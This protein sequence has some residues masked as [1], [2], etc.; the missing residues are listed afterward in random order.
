MSAVRPCRRRCGRDRHDP[1]RTPFPRQG[2]RVPCA[3]PRL[4][5]SSHAPCPLA[6]SERLGTHAERRR[7]QDP[8][9]AWQRLQTTVTAVLQSTVLEAELVALGIGKHHPS[10]GLELAPIVNDGRAEGAESFDLVGL[11]SLS[12]QQVEMHTILHGLPLR[13]RDEDEP[14]KLTVRRGDKPELVARHVDSLD[15]VARDG[16]PEGGDTPR[17]R[18]VECDVEDSSSHR[19]VLQHTAALRS[20]AAFL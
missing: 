12:R 17:I 3:L 6:L 19:V 20:R 8:C 18:A 13:N 15:L 14:G 10:T 4:W 5:L 7:L 1:S 11:L 16:A 9:S 2:F